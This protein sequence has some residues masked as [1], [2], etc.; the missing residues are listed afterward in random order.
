MRYMLYFQDISL[1]QLS[2]G[3]N[4][5][6]RSLNVISIFVFD[7]PHVTYASVVIMSVFVSFMLWYG[8]SV[9]NT[10]EENSSVFSL[11]QMH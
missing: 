3:W 9:G 1:E 7:A 10:V 5:L 2:C 11:I 4:D 6:Q 8:D